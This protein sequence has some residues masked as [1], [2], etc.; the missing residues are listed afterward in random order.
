[1]S[2]IPVR[3]SEVF[4]SEKEACDNKNNS[5]TIIVFIP[6]RKPVENDIQTYSTY[7]THKNAASTT[8]D[9]NFIEHINIDHLLASVTVAYTCL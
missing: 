2:S 8:D 7:S 4:S 3:D 1:M 5:F 6:I 9:W